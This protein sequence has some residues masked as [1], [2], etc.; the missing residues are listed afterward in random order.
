MHEQK[1]LVSLVTD[2]DFDNQTS[3]YE[4]NISMFYH[5]IKQVLDDNN[6]KYS[7]LH[8]NGLDDVTRKDNVIKFNNPQIRNMRLFTDA[9]WNE[10]LLGFGQHLDIR[11]YADPKLDAN[12]MKQ[13]RLDLSHGMDVTM[14]ASTKY[15]F[16][17][18][19]HIRKGVLDHLD[20]SKYD[21]P[22]FNPS[23]MWEIMQGLKENLDV[24]QYAN[25]AFSEA[26]M[27]KIR[28]QLKGE[29]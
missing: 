29:K 10:I 19:M 27:H 28:N 4:V 18:M 11:F 25:P 24:S 3:D 14:Y 16:E 13:I 12:Q 7:N 22:S 26:E 20:I 9:Q 23:Q 17:Q 6:I 21:N 8:I 1:I 15:D 2:A 5:A